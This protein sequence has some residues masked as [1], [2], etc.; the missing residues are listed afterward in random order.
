MVRK[1]HAVGAC[2][3]RLGHSVLTHEV[4]WNLHEHTSVRPDAPS[5]NSTLEVMK[6]SD[7]IAEPQVSSALASCAETVRPRK[8]QR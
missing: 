2:R 4:R 5:G 6:P 1:Q 8:K 3:P 7:S